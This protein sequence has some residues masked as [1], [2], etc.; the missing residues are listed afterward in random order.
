MEVKGPWCGYHNKAIADK[1]YF[2]ECDISGGVDVGIG[3]LPERNMPF[4][5]CGYEYKGKAEWTRED[6][7]GGEEDE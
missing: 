4:T 7:E 3:V 1:P 6:V 5:C 2:I